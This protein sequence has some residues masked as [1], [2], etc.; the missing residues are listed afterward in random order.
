MKIISL[1]KSLLPARNDPVQEF[2]RS[3]SQIQKNVEVV[4]GN[5]AKP[6]RAEIDI[7]KRDGCAYKT[8]RHAFDL[9]V[10]SGQALMALKEKFLEVVEINDCEDPRMAKVEAAFVDGVSRLQTIELREMRRS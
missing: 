3:L 4:V 9:P 7:T 1:I 2:A 10:S 5:G 6:N 8:L